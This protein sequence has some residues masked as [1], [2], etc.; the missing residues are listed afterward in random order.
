[1]MNPAAT[2]AND[3]IQTAIKQNASDIHFQPNFR[4]DHVYIFFRIIGLRDH[5]QSI[6]LNEYQLILTY[7]KFS[8]GMDIGE[9]RKPQ[10]GTIHL[11]FQDEEYFFR[12]ATLPVYGN[13]SLSIRI[14]PQKEQLH[15][16]K[17]FLFKNQLK[18]MKNWMNKSSGLILATGPT[19]CGKS[20]TI[21]ALL[22]HCIQ[23]QTSQVITIEDPIE[24]HIDGLLQVEVN[25]KAGINYHL[26]LKAAL[27][28]DPD[29]I[30]IGEIRDEQTAKIA[31]RAALTG[32][33]VI[34]TVHAKN[35]V[36][37]IDRLVELGIE[38]TYLQQTLI[39]IVALQL[40]TIKHKTV[41]QRTAIG[42]MLEG[43][44]LQSLIK[45]DGQDRMIQTFNDLKRKAYAYGFIKKDYFVDS[46][47]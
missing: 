29:I 43:D 17:L 18:K 46:E 11:T 12:L 41:K 21:Y 1:M 4:T 33:L 47:I 20:T 39:A 3:L 13:E 37:T 31:I 15:S 14:L 36:K 44:L 9:I 10:H 6:T 7:F 24:R 27:R 42:E 5:H 23:E 35:S 2:R 38:R 30:M 19:G 22:E 34:S 40:I 16:D 32:H 26:G 8:S 25:E 45:G 28:H